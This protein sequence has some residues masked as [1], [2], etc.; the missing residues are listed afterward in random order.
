MTTFLQLHM[1]TGYTAALLNRDDA[2]HAKSLVYGGRERTRISS[3]CLKRRWRTAEGTHALNKMD[4]FEASVRT[5]NALNSKVTAALVGDHA[6]STEDAEKVTGEINVLIYGD[7]ATDPKKRALLLLSPAEIDFAFQYAMK[8]SESL[9]AVA[10]MKGEQ[11]NKAIKSHR[12]ECWEAMADACGGTGGTI[13]AMFGRMITA[14][15]RANV[16][17]AVH[18]GHAFTV[19]ESESDL[20]YFTAVDDL[21]EDVG[22]GHVNEADLTCGLFYVYIVVDTGVLLHN[23][24]ADN[25][26]FAG[27][28]VRRLVHVASTTSAGAMKGRTSPYSYA[29]WVLAEVGQSQPRSLAEAFRQPCEPSVEGAQKAVIDH[30]N[31]LDAMYGVNEQRGVAAMSFPAEEVHAK[32]MSLGELASWLSDEVRAGA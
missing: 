18:V 21:S 17:A 8:N 15:P 27:E 10:G 24:G 22:A 9:L 31:R 5:R 32:S 13:G 19:H 25:K 20:D 23:L 3:Q 4:G 30:L 1:L 14:D 28:M 16:D 2:G 12:T 6:M 29:S 11:R 7:G 26:D